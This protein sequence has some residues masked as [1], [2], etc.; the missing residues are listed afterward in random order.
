MR[1]KRQAITCCTCFLD[2]GVGNP[3]SVIN[4]SGSN[5]LHSG[6]SGS[7]VSMRHEISCSKTLKVWAALAAL[8]S[9]KHR[10]A[11]GLKSTVWGTAKSPLKKA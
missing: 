3:S 11:N 10:T 1:C 5:K 7:K 2:M 4:K 6:T 9:G 8:T